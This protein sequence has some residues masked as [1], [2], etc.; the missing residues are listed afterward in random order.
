MEKIMVALDDILLSH[1]QCFEI[2]KILLETIF[3]QYDPEL[4]RDREI[5][6]YL[7]TDFYEILGK[8]Q[9]EIIIELKDYSKT[10]DYHTALQEK[11]KNLITIANELNKKEFH[12]DIIYFMNI[13]C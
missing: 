5:R 4:V 1:R 9:Q 6:K 10:A 13:L 8:K 2:A 11:N 3:I 12:D 7:V